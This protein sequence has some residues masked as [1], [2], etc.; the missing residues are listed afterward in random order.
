MNAVTKL[1]SPEPET[2]NSRPRAS[3]HLSHTTQAL[4]DVL[5][6]G[7]AQWPT[8]TGPG[9]IFQ[10]YDW[11]QT[12]WDVASAQAQRSARAIVVE[13]GNRGVIVPITSALE[14]GPPQLTWADNDFGC[15]DFRTL[16]TATMARI[17]ATELASQSRFR[18]LFDN[19]R[20]RSAQHVAE[21]LGQLGW[22]ASVEQSHLAPS[23]PLEE[24]FDAYLLARFSGKSRSQLRRR[25]RD[26]N[27]NG[28]HIID[29]HVDG[30]IAEGMAHLVRLHGKR[31]EN[32]GVFGDPTVLRFHTLLTQRLAQR[33]QLRLST[34]VMDGKP[35]AAY[36]GYADGDTAAFYQSGRDTKSD[37]SGGS[38]LI[39]HAIRSA[40]DDGCTRFDLLRGAE[41]YKARWKPDPTTT[42]R[43]RAYAPGV[44]GKLS[45]GAV[46]AKEL[47]R[48]LLKRARK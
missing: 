14:R 47:A 35:I 16:G 44:R 13:V 6:R 31:W 36:Y 21:A 7:D 34:L 12:W 48:Q 33:G 1:S 46:V 45:Q 3:G 9:A 26:A 17:V 43:V 30:S 8:T 28:N 25:L 42:W 22:V 5:A 32:G 39:A 4:G 37:S 24:S 23:I 15:P 10:S 41:T 18:L 2:I 40:I 27:K 38:V 19:L 11:W 29:H 20:Q